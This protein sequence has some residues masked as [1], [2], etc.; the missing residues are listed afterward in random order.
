MTTLTILR[1]VPASGKTTHAMQLQQT[2]YTRVCRDDIRFALYGKYWGV[3][4]DVVTQ[5][6]N[7]MIEAA[8]RAEQDTVV[9]ATNFSAR[10]LRPKLSLAARYGAD[11]EYADFPIDVTHAIA[12][13]E[14]RERTVGEDVIRHFYKQYKIPLDGS[15]LPRPPEPLPMF[16]LYACDTTKPLAYIVDTDGTVADHRGVR[17]PYDTTK[18]YADRVRTHVARVVN[19]LYND[20]YTIIGLSG[21]DSAFRDVTTTW[22]G[23]NGIQFSQFFM[24]AEGDKRMDAIVKYE[25][26]KEHIEPDYQVMGAFDDRPQVLR[27]WETIGVPVFNVGEGVEF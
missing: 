16:E 9:D 11:V 3:D 10:Y 22:W 19:A 20:Q 23:D 2:G 5:V 13:D 25:L 12:R 24:R 17:N 8:L 1:G 27:M 14:G 18:Y 15:S 26:F 6:E 21:R 7:S 4:E